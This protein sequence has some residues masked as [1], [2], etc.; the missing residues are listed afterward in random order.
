MNGMTVEVN[1]ANCI[2]KQTR[3]V[4]Q[5]Y[6]SGLYIPNR[7]WSNTLIPFF[8]CASGQSKWPG[9]VLGQVSG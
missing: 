7:L 2:E 9:Q 3:R 8:I 6:G 4:R 1:Q 5:D